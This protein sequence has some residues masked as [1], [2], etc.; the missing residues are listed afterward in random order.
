MF[1]SSLTITSYLL[2]DNHSTAIYRIK[3]SVTRDTMALE[4]NGSDERKESSVNSETQV[5]DKS[6]GIIFPNDE[7]D[8][9]KEAGE[10][11]AKTTHLTGWA[12]VILSIGLSVTTFLV[13]LDMMII[14]TVS[15]K[16]RLHLDSKSTGNTAHHN[17]VQKFR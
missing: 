2:H 16:K 6:N 4:K 1:G 11:Q 5:N 8:D 9:F 3:S 7:K 13:G 17:T 15:L 10:L 12:M 14:A